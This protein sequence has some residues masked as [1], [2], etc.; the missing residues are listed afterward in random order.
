MSEKELERAVID[1]LRNINAEVDEFS[2]RRPGK[3][4]KCGEPVYSGTQ[5]TLG[6]PDLRVVFARQKV[7]L[8][9][10]LKWGKNKP[11]P[12]Q[13][14]WLTRECL[15]GTPATVIYSMEDLAWV[16]GA[17]GIMKEDPTFRPHFQTVKFIDLWRFAGVDDGADSDT[18]AQDVGL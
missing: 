9:L 17:I 16:L 12:D 3:C 6:I 4:K 5:Q 15:R 10:E 14:V 11:S 13:V 18:I 1:N 8:W 2:Q 7:T